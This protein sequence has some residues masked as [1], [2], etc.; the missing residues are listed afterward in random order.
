MIYIYGN[1][2]NLIDRYNN[3]L[4]S[5]DYKI[6]RNKDEL[7]KKI[8]SNDVVIISNLNFEIESNLELIQDFNKKE[9]KIIILDPVP[10]FDKGK[11]FIGMGVKAYANIMINDVHLKD[12]INSVIAGNIWLYPE[13]INLL[14]SNLTL[15]NEEK[16]IQNEKLDILTDREKEVALLVLNKVPYS[17]ISEKL[18]I[19]IRTVK[20][21]T[22]HIYEKFDVSNRLSFI[23]K[24]S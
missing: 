16:N 10:T 18:N 2:L 22:K 14:V 8:Q 3:S 12:V 6:T 23:L 20:A 19:S 5:F 7:L 9:I 15:S 24:F 17:S 13:F 4:K 21:H 1:D 11:K